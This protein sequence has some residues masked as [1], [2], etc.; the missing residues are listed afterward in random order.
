VRLSEPACPFCGVE[1]PRAFREQTAPRTPA[2]RLN[3]AALYAL[4]MG[5]IS[6]TAA[7]CGGSIVI[8]SSGGGGEGNGATSDD[9]SL[10]G[11]SSTGGGSSSSVGWTS[12]GGASEDAPNQIP[13]PLYGGFNG[14]P[15]PPPPADAAAT[16]A[17]RADGAAVDAGVIHDAAAMNDVAE[18]YDAP[19]YG[20]LYGGFTGA[21]YGGICVPN[22]TQCSGNGFQT[23]STSG[24][25]GPAT[26]C[27]GQACVNGTCVGSC[28]PA[29]VRCSGGIVQTCD[30]RGAWSVPDG[31]VACSNDGG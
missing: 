17:D 21:L 9:G 19:F 7:A 25:W 8:T 13:I 10:G 28:V 23:C 18:G 14:Y 11:G 16:D 26:P 22:A 29:S 1:L 6:A 24:V 20:A 4:R 12:S 30:A 31:G 5:A 2:E 3:R 27:V 15:P